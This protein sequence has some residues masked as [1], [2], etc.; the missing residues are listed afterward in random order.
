LSII[1]PIL[2]T[3]RRLSNS[4]A[5]RQDSFDN[6]HPWNQN[7]ILSGEFYVD[8]SSS[9]VSIPRRVRFHSRDFIRRRSSTFI[10]LP[11]EIIGTNIPLRTESALARFSRQ[12]STAKI[13][14]EKDQLAHH[15]SSSKSNIKEKKF[16]TS[17]SMMNSNM[18]SSPTAML[19]NIKQPY[20]SENRIMAT[21]STNNIKKPILVIKSPENSSKTTSRNVRFVP[22]IIADD[23]QVIPSRIFSS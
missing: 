19:K 4:P 17:H 8:R 20:R 18:Q 15:S 9:P 3:P 10:D 13:L 16:I 7:D 23:E 6:L 14:E 5:L 11:I 2:S 12:K 22:E 21:T 1:S